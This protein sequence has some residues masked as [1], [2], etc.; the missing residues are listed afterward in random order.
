ICA[1][2]IDARGDINLNGVAYEVSDAVVFSNYFVYGL[3]VFT[4]NLDG[5]IAA[6][7]VNADGVTLSVADLVY[8]IRVIVG[9]SPA[10]PKLSPGQTP[11]AQLAVR[12]GV[13]SV[14]ASDYRIGAISLILDGEAEPRL[15]E[16]ASAMEMR[17]SFDGERTRVLIYNMNGTAFLETG[18][19]LYVGGDVE[20]KSLD[21]GGYDGFTLVSKLN[22][23]PEDFHLSQNYPNPFNPTT[24]IEYYIPHAS[25]IKITVYN[26]MGQR[27]K[28]LLD[29][30]AEAGYG[31]VSWD[32]TDDSGKR[33]ASGLYLN[34]LE[35][36][37]VALTRRMLL[38]K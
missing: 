18:P 26:V 14:S 7:D 17:Y 31:A 19:V 2:S 6:T 21:V 4:V 38:L 11:K 27:V 34:R 16:N 22:E 1:D 5:Q 8:L 25:R 33:V 12:N 9:D 28:V 36:E 29:K 35:A 23:L 13:L 30:Y 32:A 10:M 24:R 20:V 37:G 3:P 15:H